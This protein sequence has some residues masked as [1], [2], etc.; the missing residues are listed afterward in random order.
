MKYE[1]LISLVSFL[2]TLLGVNLDLIK[3]S[4][5]NYIDAVNGMGKIPF[6]RTIRPWLF[7]EFLYY[8][9]TKLGKTEINWLDIIHMFSHCVFRERQALNNNVD[10]KQE[11][12]SITKKMRVLDLLLKAK[13][14]GYVTEEEIIDEISGIIFGVSIT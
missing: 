13:S 14:D 8:N 11:D 10:K 9:L 5:I 12:D 3:Q 6:Y 4:D 2:E 7:N 1:C